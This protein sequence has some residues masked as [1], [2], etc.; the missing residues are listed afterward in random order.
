MLSIDDIQVLTNWR[1]RAVDKG[2]GL[3]LWFGSKSHWA[4]ITTEAMNTV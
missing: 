3:R 2:T 1:G 4:G